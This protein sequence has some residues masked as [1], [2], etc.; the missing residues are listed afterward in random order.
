MH[1]GKYN[2]HMFR[3]TYLNTSLLQFSY[4]QIDKL[5]TKD[6]KKERK[7]PGYRNWGRAK[8]RAQGSL[9]RG[10]RGREAAAT[11][12]TPR[13]STIRCGHGGARRHRVTAQAAGG[14]DGTWGSM[15]TRGGGADDGVA[16]SG[17][18][19]GQ[20]GRLRP[21]AMGQHWPG[22]RRTWAGAEEQP[23]YGEERRGTGNIR[24]FKCVM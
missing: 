17:V 2:H 6:L 10:T 4:P 5:Q 19:Q 11:A 15:G 24:K 3:Q 18:G 7:I 13:Q 22:P 8:Q 20:E 1:Q 12:A 14:A 9:R 21:G 16:G 23:E